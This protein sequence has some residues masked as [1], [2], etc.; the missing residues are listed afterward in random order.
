M[1]YEVLA[2]KIIAA[3][4]GEENIKSLTHCVTRLRFKLT[5]ELLA[6]KVALEALDGVLGVIQSGG[7]YQVVIGNHVADVYEDVLQ[8]GRIS[9]S[10]AVKA[11]EVEVTKAKESMLN[12]LLDIINS[13]FSP[14]LGVLAGAGMI[15]GLVSL[16]VVV[17]FVQE[18]TGTYQILHATGD[19]L[20]YF[21][22]LVLGKNAM[23]KFG[24]NEIIGMVL[25]GVLVYPS[26]V[27]TM[28][29]TPLYTLF[30]GSM[31]ESPVYLEFFGLPVIMMNYGS[32]VIP[33]IAA[34]ALAAP[35]EKWFKKHLHDAVSSML[36]PFL[37]LL[38][39]APLTILVVGVLATWLSLLI[40]QGVFNLYQV[41]PIVTGLV[42]GGMWQVLVIFGLHW[43]LV[44]LVYLNMSTLGYDPVIS[45]TFAASFAQIGA[46]LAVVLKTNDKTLKTNGLSAFFTGIFGITEPAIYGVTLARKKAFIAS[47]IGA[48]LGG[49]ILGL[50]GSA[51]YSAGG[52]G[53]FGLPNKIHPSGIGWDFYGTIIAII[54]AF[55]VGFGLTLVMT[56]QD[57]IDL[58]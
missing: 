23:K 29:A 43:G 38:L 3:V 26:L 6:N 32:S 41:S 24:G 16:L 27:A 20:F 34:A 36:T 45:L 48:A 42:L 28:Q 46:V 10:G 44:P 56:K 47:C 17:G 15:K 54:L 57:E 11:D 51:S 50:F 37:T 14:M 5:D 18:G 30:A 25:G 1:E 12:K 8:V 13:V 52:L 31:I 53:V 7:Q 19:A 9:G 39:V 58:M 2:K 22:P 55:I 49:M 35:I 40:G 33:V 4:G 21:F